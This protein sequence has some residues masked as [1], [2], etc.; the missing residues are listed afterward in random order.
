MSK[1]KETNDLLIF[2]QALI[3]R[4]QALRVDQGSA[5]IARD[6]RTWIRMTII[7]PEYVIAVDE[8]IGAQLS[9]LEDFTGLVAGDLRAELL[10]LRTYLGVHVIAGMV[11]I[12]E[13]VDLLDEKNRGGVSWVR[14]WLEKNTLPEECH[15]PVKQALVEIYNRDLAHKDGMKMEF[16]VPAKAVDLAL[17]ELQKQIDAA[18]DKQHVVA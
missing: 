14:E 17:A 10:S 12:I 5:V 2:E 13:A 7:R 18:A 3:Q 1:E 16:A 15:E 4:I 11:S 8:A 6:L 9:E